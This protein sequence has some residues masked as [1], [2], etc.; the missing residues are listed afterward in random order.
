MEILAT[1]ERASRQQINTDKTTLFF[2]KS[3]SQEVQDAIKDALGVPVVQQYEKYLGL[4]SFIGRK[5]KESFDNIK[6]QVWKKLQGWEGKLLSQAGREILI[7]AVAQA[8]PTYTMSCFKL[9]SG[10]CHDIEA[11]IRRFF[12]GQRG[13]GRKVHWIRWEDLC[14][15]KSQGGLGFKDLSHFN[16][17]LLAKQTWR[18]LHDKTS[19]F[20]RVFKAKF[21]PNCSVMEAASQ[22]SASY[23]WKSIIRGREVIRKGAIWRIGNGKS[24][25]IWRDRWLPLKHSPKILSPRRNMGSEAKVCSFIDQDQRCWKLDVLVTSLMAFEAAMVRSIPLCH[26]DQ[27]NVLIWPH[28]PNGEYSVKSG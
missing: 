4:P 13:D 26:T 5:K 1:Y 7:K 12:W 14:K 19:L 15:P 9:P 17:A 8:L 6:Q 28:N 18:L 22:S 11:L 24:V 3:T 25:D 16:D 27:P 2:S 10:L 20:Y 21:F 23:A